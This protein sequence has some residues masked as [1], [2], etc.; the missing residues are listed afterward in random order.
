MTELL[1]C[2]LALGYVLATGV[3]A[4]WL[5]RWRE[6]LRLLEICKPEI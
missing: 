3:V 5:G 1:P 2:P 6:Q 4:Y